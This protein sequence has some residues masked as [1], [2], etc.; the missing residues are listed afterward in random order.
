MGDIYTNPPQSRNEAIIRATIDGTEYTDPPQSR[1]EDLLIELK[2][3]IEQGGGGGTTVIA[4]P[5]LAGT[6]DNLTGLQ[7]GSTKYKVPSGGSGSTAWGSITGTIGDQTDLKNA[8][9][10]KFDASN[11]VISG[12]GANLFTETHANWKPGM[13]VGE[14]YTPGTSQS[15]YYTTNLWAYS[16]K[17]KIKFSIVEMPSYFRACLYDAEYNFLQ[18]SGT[19][20]TD[21]D[22]N[23]VVQITKTNVA[24]MCFVMA[25]HAEE[26]STLVVGRY[27]AFGA[28]KL[29]FGDLYF[30]DE[31]VTM[32]R[33]RLGLDT[34]DI[35]NGKKWAVAGDSFT[36]GD[37][38]TDTIPSGTY[39]GQ[40]AVYPFLIAT[41]HN[42]TIQ[43]FF[44]NG[45]TLALPQDQTSTNAFAY[46]YQT[47]AADADYLTIYLGINDS[48]KA[49]A[50]TGQI[51]IG[52]ISDNTTATFYGAWN[53]IL[54]WLIANRPNLKIG[55]IVSNG[56][57]SDDYR[58]ASI[59]IANKYGIPYIDMNG[60]ERTPCMIRSSNASI[61][62]SVRNQRT[63]N[64]RVSSE[65]L[66]PNAAC[67]AY[68]STFIENFLKT[69]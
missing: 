23:Y 47:V 6:E 25:T 15:T 40:Y 49:S 45:R 56:C 38:I 1:M 62:S 3:T 17:E 42:M 33:T 36:H 22:G 43:N 27:D 8:L 37:G 68:E 9:D 51:P 32:A 67:H 20:T 7:V 30:S 35:L 69:L 10:A 65:N 44:E 31:N 60:D 26:F 19:Y 58:T 4:N 41:R 50:E 5:T 24:Y 14:K 28:R 63:T 34:P 13:S 52:T 2:E 18:A 64:W 16:S 48:H 21:T 12:G 66:H 54:S 57:D 46:Y 39:Q 59:A 29:V 11:A 61:D 55:I 53:V